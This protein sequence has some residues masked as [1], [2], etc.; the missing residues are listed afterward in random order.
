MVRGQQQVARVAIDQTFHNPAPRV[1]EGMFR[2][3]IPGDAS[4]Q[5]LAMYVEGRLT[6][7]AVVERMAA[8]RIYEDVVYRRLDPALLE[9]AGTGRELFSG[10]RAIVGTAETGASVIRPL[11]APTEEA[12]VVQPV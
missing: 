1:M 6:E 3:A 4:L 8:R 5:R 9:W 10:F 7:S 11:P 2:F 12:P